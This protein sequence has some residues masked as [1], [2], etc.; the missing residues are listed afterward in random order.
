[1]Y[2]MLLE[3]VLSLGQKKVVYIHKLVIPQT[4]EERIQEVCKVEL[5]LAE[6]TFNLRLLA[7]TH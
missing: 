2:L 6:L 3:R 7:R 4:V 1:M 5:I